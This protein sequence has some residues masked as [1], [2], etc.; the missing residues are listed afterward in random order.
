MRKDKSELIK[1]LTEKRIAKQN[2]TSGEAASQKNLDQVQNKTK[3]EKRYVKH[4]IIVSSYNFHNPER[5]NNKRS[6]YQI[7]NSKQI[8]RQ[9]SKSRK[10]K[11][12]NATNKR[13]DGEFRGNETV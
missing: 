12:T 1:K 11:N 9:A 8:D 3:G 2:V 7:D 5:L 6:K 10:I 13:K 4:S